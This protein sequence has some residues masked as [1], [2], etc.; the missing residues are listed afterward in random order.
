MAGKILKCSY[1]ILAVTLA[2]LLPESCQDVINVDLRNAAPRI[3][4]EGSVSNLSDSVIVAVHFS[5]DFYTPESIT[6]VNDAVLTLKDSAGTDH[7]LSRVADGIYKA[8]NISAKPGDIFDLVIAEA[9]NSYTSVATMPVLVKID[10]VFI[11]R[12]PD[13]RDGDVVN[14]RI[15]DPA[16][17]PDYYQFE[18]FRN[19][20]LLNTGNNF[21]IVS[22][23]Y[24]DGKTG[25]LPIGG[26]RLGINTFNSGD[27]ITVRMKNIEKWM[28]DYLDILRSITNQE[29]I[30]SITTPANP[31]GNI[32]G[33][34]LGYFSANSISV[35]TIIK[36]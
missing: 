19:D 16:G 1:T 11:T 12:D 22:D 9:G 33:N 29:A 10:S 36:Q 21:I 8:G 25:S 5:T 27:R 7:P 28:Y 24:F 6:P 2:V 18:I 30:F 26:R 4:I 17:I 15:K 3:V 23:K 32:S 14:V 20:S 35:K 34:A 13:R 31:P